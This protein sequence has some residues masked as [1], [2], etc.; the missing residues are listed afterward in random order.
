MCWQKRQFYA[1]QPRDAEGGVI[2]CCVLANWLGLSEL[3]LDES[4]GAYLLFIEQT[5][6]LVDQHPDPLQRKWTL[7]CKSSTREQSLQQ[8][9]RVAFV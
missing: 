8:C 4:L 3:E 1:V 7:V 5:A 6:A 9:G 2:I